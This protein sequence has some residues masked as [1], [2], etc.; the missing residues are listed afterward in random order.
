MALLVKQGKST[1]NFRDNRRTETRVTVYIPKDMHEQP[2]I[3]KL[4]SHSGVTVNIATAQLLG[5]VPQKGC[6]DLELRGTVFQIASALTY[7][8]ELNL[9]I[10]H[11][12][13][14]GQDGW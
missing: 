12:A 5:D 14:V 7:L 2:V 1:N 10:K 4:I 9:E 13:V 3:S 6:L 11:K 8:D